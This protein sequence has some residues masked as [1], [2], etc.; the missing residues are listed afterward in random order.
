MLFAER[1][2]QGQALLQAGLGEPCRISSNKSSMSPL[3]CTM[4]GQHCLSQGSRVPVWGFYVL[5]PWG[6]CWEQNTGQS[7]SSCNGGSVDGSLWVGVGTVDTWT[8]AED[9]ETGWKSGHIMAGNSLGR[10]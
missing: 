6:F 5:S 9:Y 3:C 1:W 4:S 10:G 7:Q 8:T 2:L